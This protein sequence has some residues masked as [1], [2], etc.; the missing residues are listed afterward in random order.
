MMD[1]PPDSAVM[2]V[3]DDVGLQPGR[4]FKGPPT[5]PEI[6]HPE[7]PSLIHDVRSE[8]RSSM[9]RPHEELAEDEEGLATPSAP[10][11]KHLFHLYQVQKRRHHIKLHKYY[12]I[13]YVLVS[14]MVHHQKCF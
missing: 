11:N 14:D 8:S 3:S 5:R 1:T 4:R 7:D 6:G 12:Y 9:C 13:Q 2:N 10:H